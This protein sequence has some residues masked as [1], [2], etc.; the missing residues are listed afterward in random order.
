MCAYTGFRDRKVQVLCL[1]SRIIAIAAGTTTSTTPV[2]FP[3]SIATAVT[4]T[5]ATTMTVRSMVTLL[6]MNTGMKKKKKKAMII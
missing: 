6:N 3:L 5:A 1:A 4:I 2:Y